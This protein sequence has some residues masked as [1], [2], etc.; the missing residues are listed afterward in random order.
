M[1]PS[2][3]SS[4]SS[5]ASR[6]RVASQWPRRMDDFENNLGPEFADLKRTI[7]EQFGDEQIRKSWI[8]VCNR[9]NTI[10]CPRLKKLG[11]KAI[12]SFTFEQMLEA[13]D[14]E[15]A[16][17]KDAGCV[18][19]K[20]LFDVSLASQWREMSRD[21]ISE[22]RSLATGIPRNNDLKSVWDIYWSPA[23]V[24][25]RGHPNMLKIQTLMNNLWFDSDP[26]DPEPIHLEQPYSYADRLRLREPGDKNFALGPHIDAG[27]LER[28]QDEEYRSVYAAVFS[29]QFHKFQDYDIRSR[30]SANQN[31]YGGTAG[32]HVLRTW[33][34]WTSLS[35]TAPNEG[36]LSLFPS[37]NEAIAY[38]LLRPFFSPPLEGKKLAASWVD[39]STWTFDCTSAFPGS[40]G[41][42]SQELGAISHP[43]LRLKECLI[44]LPKVEPGDQVFWH[45][46]VCFNFVILSAGRYLSLTL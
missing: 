18:V 9:L 2:V 16:S 41:G 34:G 30:L 32:C 23:Q 22:N 15:I 3:T 17:I 11:T 37:V 12:P 27:S 10:V 44:P 7:R 4:I 42:K 25:A 21:Y 26:E 29:G 14:A 36:S 38:I 24:A 35:S 13:S 45:S 19:V 39:P 28:W 31:L 40:I 33:Q 46:D 6:L 5:D 20:G 8:D 1:A 43:H